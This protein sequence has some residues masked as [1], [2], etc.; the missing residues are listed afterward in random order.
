MSLRLKLTIIL[1]L[2]TLIP[3]S[4][5]VILASRV[6]TDRFDAS[7]IEGIK[8]GLITIQLECDEVSKDALSRVRSIS[9][10]RE[11]KR[12]LLLRERGRR[13]D[14]IG[15]IG[16]VERLMLQG[17]L[18][19]LTLYGTDGV[20]LARGHEASRFGDVLEDIEV[21]SGEAERTGIYR[22]LF[23]GRESLALVATIPVVHRGRIIGIIDGGYLLDEEFLE[24]LK[25]K[26]D[27]EVFLFYEERPILATI[28]E[29]RFPSWLIG[30]FEKGLPYLGKATI[31]E[32]SYTL[33]SIPIDGATI[34]VGFS[35]EGLIETIGEMRRVFFVLAI[36]GCGV[37]VVVGS[38]MAG[39][40]TRPLHELLLGVRRVAHGNLDHHIKSERRDELGDLIH[41]FNQMAKDL[42]ESREAL[43]RAE[44]IAAWR[45]IARRVAH[46]IKNPLTP[47]QLC[48]QD[49]KRRFGE[50]REE[51][52]ETA[53]TILDEVESLRRIADEF[54]RFAR[55][56]G[57]RME[58]CDI[59][60]VI[61][62]VL[63]L[64][65][66]SQKGVEIRTTFA[67][68]LPHIMADKGQLR[69]VFTNLIKN[70]LEA[71]NKKGEILIHTSK[72]DD[73]VEVR[74]K[75]TG[76]GVKEEDLGR[77]FDPFFTTKDG[78]RGLGLSIVHRILTEHGGGVECVSKLGEGAT[79]IIRLPIEGRG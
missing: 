77:I 5:V 46:E 19:I 28:K 62:G 40:I 37:A 72:T 61:E 38:I 1:T 9:G 43:L 27:A 54:S 53:Q 63:T 8:E 21:A 15:L 73:H 31:G 71:C 14:Q 67:K 48:V 70:S 51:I 25:K 18:D 16:V 57:P 41:S 79:F 60:E 52:E 32:K 69:E 20:V 58:P 74:I 23:R 26:I 11:L 36:I 30:E 49:L 68:G 35:R 56:P 33:G 39:G 50:G 10:E 47:I 45:D 12:I 6:V 66:D 75:D 78:G 7:F 3:M 34:M 59:N 44:R 22:L 2:I 64:H 24:R 29:K 4:I 17:G 55:M 13:F 65:R 76:P 42:K